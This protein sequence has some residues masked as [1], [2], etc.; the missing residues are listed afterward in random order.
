M[1]KKMKTRAT[2]TLVR[3]LIIELL[4]YGVLLVGY[5]FLVLRFLGGFL[6]DLFS[7]HIELYAFL[8]LGLIVVQ[9]VI[10]EALTS[11]LIRMLRLD[12]YI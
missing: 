3:N 11:F 12:R 2:K 7:N 1:E 9:A 8:G 5:F 10:L 6:T 4:V